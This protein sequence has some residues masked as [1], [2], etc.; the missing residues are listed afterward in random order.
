[1][2]K[3]IQKM[4]LQTFLFPNEV[5]RDSELYYRIKRTDRIKGIDRIKRID[6][7]TDSK[8][9]QES[10]EDRVV[11]EKKEEL[12]CDTYMNLMDLDAWVTYTKIRQIVLCVTVSGTGKLILM[13]MQKEGDRKRE[14]IYFDGQQAQSYQFVIQESKLHGMIYFRLLAETRVVFYGASY[15]S[16]DVEI[17]EIKISLVICTYQREKQLKENLERLSKSD[18]FRK[19][20]ERNGKLCVRVVDNAGERKE[21]NEWKKE[22]WN[23]E[24][25]NT[26]NWN[27][28][29]WQKEGKNKENGNKKNWHFYHNRNTGGSGGFTRGIVESQKDRV[30]FP[31]THILLMDDDVKLQLESLYRLYA[32][33]SLIKE[34]YFGEVVAGR[35]F[36]LD[37]KTVQYTAADIWNGGWIQHVGYN[38][39]M[40]QRRYFY[41]MNR[42]RG[43]YAGW[44]FA[45]FPMEYTIEN[46]PIPFF[47]HCDDVEYGLRHGGQPIVLNG[48][49][50]WHE[51]CNYRQ[52]AVIHYY[53][54][55][56][57]AFTNTKI[58][59]PKLKSHLIKCWFLGLLSNIRHR[60][61]QQEYMKLLA[62]QDYAK[63]EEWLY[64]IDPEQNHKRI[65]REAKRRIP[66]FLVLIK[67]VIIWIKILCKK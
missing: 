13:E 21:Q 35:M 58:Q 16:E 31:A 4:V 45:C 29:N 66:I 52:S 10:E 5:C 2:E 37:Q 30:R 12:S 18:F 19:G 53:D 23:T 33:L 1:M 62:I 36:C 26:K 43:E 41:S 40:V 46:L 27:E 14:E 48:I 9:K 60:R 11:L 7:G 17:R 6:E 63:G 20:S 65:C 51:T 59:Y 57:T 34:E 61:W 49:Q 8:T 15:F 50:V 54:V 47:L 24:N 38:Q 25:W 42:E 32:L 3:G 55:R 56:N 64:Q 22:N 28:E 44:W 39:D 67:E